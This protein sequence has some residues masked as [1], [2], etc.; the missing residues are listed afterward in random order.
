VQTLIWIPD[1]LRRQLDALAAERNETL[2]AISTELLSAALNTTTNYTPAT[3]TKASNDAT[4]DMFAT[5]TKE[6]D[7]S[8]VSVG[9]DKDALMNEVGKLRDAGLSGEEIARRLNAAGHR[10]AKG[11]ELIGN[12]LLRDYRKWRS[13][14]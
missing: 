12:N 5:N 11:T 1:G 4:L 13:E 2:S 6:N 9:N 10:T 8:F 3:T 7:F 14:Q